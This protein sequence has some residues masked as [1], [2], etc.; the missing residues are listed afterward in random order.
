MKHS[1]AEFCIFFLQCGNKVLKDPVIITDKHN[2]KVRKLVNINISG[3]ST[4]CQYR[5]SYTDTMNN[6][7]IKI[8]LL[9]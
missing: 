5:F 8:T 2:P 7:L 4:Q 1:V 9:Y 3:K 6:F